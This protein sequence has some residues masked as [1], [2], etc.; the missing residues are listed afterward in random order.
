ML[1]KSFRAAKSLSM[2]VLQAPGDLT[3]TPERYRSYRKEKESKLKE[4]KSEKAVWRAQQNMNPIAGS[5]DGQKVFSLDD[6]DDGPPV[7]PLPPRASA[8]DDAA[9][10]PPSYESAAHVSA[11]DVGIFVQPKSPRLTVVDDLPPPPT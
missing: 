3:R 1:V 7:P 11:D 5:V 2:R 9:V 10:P 8:D 6:V 4:A